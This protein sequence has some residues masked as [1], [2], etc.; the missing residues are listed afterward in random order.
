[1][2]CTIRTRDRHISCFISHQRRGIVEVVSAVIVLCGVFRSDAALGI[3]AAEGSAG[4]PERS[5]QQL[6]SRSSNRSAEPSGSSR[7][8]PAIARQ[9][10]EQPEDVPVKAWIL[11]TDKGLE[12]APAVAEAATRL[13]RTY[14]PR[15]LERRQR[16]RTLPG[17]FDVHDLPVSPLYVDAVKATGARVHVV[18]RWVNGVS[19]RVTRRQ[20][21]EIERL[22]FVKIIQPV[23]WGRRVEPLELPPA[24]A[25]G[26]PLATSRDPSAGRLEYGRSEGELNQINLIGV[27]EQGYTGEGVVVGILDTGFRREHEAFNEPGHVLEV[28]AEWD[29]VE[30][31][32]NTG[33]EPGDLSTQHAHGTQVL[34]ILGAYKPGELIGAAY[35]ASFILCK[36]EDDGSEQPIEEDNYV[37]GLEFIEANGGDVATASLGYIAWYTQEDLDGMTA[38]T[39]IAVNVATANG[40]FCCNAAGNSGHDSNPQ[41]S[42][43]I[44]PADA[45]QVLTC[46]AVG[47]EGSI[48]N[49]SSDGPTADGRVKPE[50]LARG[51]ATSTVSAYTNDVYSSPHGTSMSTPLVAGAVACLVQAHPTWTVSQMRAYLFH[52]ADYYVAH[53]TFDRRYVR[54]YGIIDALAALAED[55]NGNGVADELDLYVGTSVDCNANGFPD[56]CEPGDV[57]GDERLTLADIA[58]YPDC[59]TGPCGQP[60]CNP[61]LFTDPCCTITDFD[62]DGD[63][64]LADWAAFQTALYHP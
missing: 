45:F 24:T 5:D 4:S 48:A 55:C 16:R 62:T 18:S 54:G 35:D 25:G 60:P 64:D 38:V 7:T 61:P 42:S 29:C 12:G 51:V 2:G 47:V 9:L 63:N 13:G 50:V 15:A 57:D 34:G 26:E 41:T 19:A 52:T 17:L 28:V 37:A 21:A 23:R 31:D 8:H 32:G 46:G 58:G 20:V 3:P 44:A 59:V 6:A 43:L 56:E 33:I 40:V 11:F 36:T 1:M 39:T 10:A 22:P 30:Q 14:H 49:F 53:G 27:H